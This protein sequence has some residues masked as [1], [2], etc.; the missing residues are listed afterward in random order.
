MRTLTAALLSS[1]LLFGCQMQ[2][3]K[4]T[5]AQIEV[6]GMKAKQEA[7]AHAERKLIA[8]SEQ[9]LPVAQRELAI[10]YQSRP[11]QRA[12]ALKLF[13]QAARGGDVEAAFQLGEMLR[14]GVLGV[15]AAPAAAAP[16]YA[17]AAQHQHARAALALGLMV[18]NGNGVPRDTARAA[19]LLTQA[20]EL[21]NAHAMFLL[22]NIYREGDGV[23]QDTVKARSWLEEAAEHEYPPALQ[24][25]AM[26]VQLGDALSARDERRAGELMKEASE[27]RRNNWNRF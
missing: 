8:W 5:S 4:P 25:L 9:N 2:Q 14:I 19:R 24:E 11:E 15:P 13:E 22:S 7:D 10:L 23:A 18:R 1:V 3:E 27:H 12:D 21:G 17:L 26:T 6:T 20:A 16:W